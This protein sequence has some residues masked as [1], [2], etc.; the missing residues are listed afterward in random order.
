[1]RNEYDYSSM[2]NHQNQSENLLLQRL[3]ICMMLPV[4]SRGLLH[5]RSHGVKLFDLPLVHTFIPSLLNTMEHQYDYRLYIGYD[6]DDPWYDN[7][8]NWQDLHDFIRMNMKQES[9]FGL[10]LEVKPKILYGID[11]RIT[12]IWNSLATAAYNDHCDYFYQANDDMLIQTKGWTSSAI[13]TLEQCPVGKNFGVVAFNDLTAC[14]YPTFHLTHRTH[15]DLHDGIYYPL[16]SHG[17]HQD[18]WIFSMYRPWRCAV[19]LR[20]YRV[21]NHVGLSVKARYDYG[22]ERPL[23]SWIRRSRTRLYHLL[24]TEYAT[25]YNQSFVNASSINLDLSFTIPC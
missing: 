5:N 22:D 21:K 1:M 2:P 6:V 12:A 16:P 11:Q 10:H 25:R 7:T 24:S 19:V 4:T 13:R 8:T 3:S 17:A 20:Q 23:Q 9:R 15:L 18:P 14:E